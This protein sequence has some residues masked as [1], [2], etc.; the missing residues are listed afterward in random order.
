MPPVHPLAHGAAPRGYRRIGKQ[1]L[2]IDMAEKLLREAHGAR[3]T[4]EPRLFP[5]DPARAVSMGLTQESYLQLLRLA[6]FQPRHPP[7][8]PQGAFGPSA[9]VLWRWRPPRRDAPRPSDS[10]PRPEGAFAALAELVR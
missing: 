9:P 1:A 7:Q 5:L 6:G 8:M 2:R 3:V 10:R 4:A